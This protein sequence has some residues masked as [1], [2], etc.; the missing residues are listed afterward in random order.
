[1]TIE[2]LQLVRLVY[3]QLRCL[4]IKLKI[5]KLSTFLFLLLRLDF[6]FFLIQES[7]V[8]FY[9]CFSQ[10]A[11]NRWISPFPGIL[12]QQQQQAQVP[13]GL[14]FPLTTLESF[15]GLFPN[16]IPFS[17]QFG[18]TQ[19]SQAGP[20][21]LSQQQT[22]PQTP[23]GANLVSQ[24]FFY[25]AAVRQY[26]KQYNKSL[27]MSYVSYAVS[28][29]MKSISLYLLILHIKITLKSIALD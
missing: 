10:G 19:V 4:L 15:A 8:S 1:M 3:K 14:Q 16:Q 28:I 9:L 25:P 2:T 5:Y 17:G 12:Q 11:F 21:E 22:P 20:P 27:I 29:T 6:K 7:N 24:N 18:I 26:I 13:G 23:Q